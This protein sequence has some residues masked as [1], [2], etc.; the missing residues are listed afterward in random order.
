MA[1]EIRIPKLGLTMTDAVLSGWM[2]SAGEEVSADQ[3]VCALETDKVSFEV[4]APCTGWLHPVIAAGIRVEV[5]EVVGYVAADEAELDDLKTRFAVADTGAVEAGAAAASTEDDAD[6]AP[7]AA[8]ADSP[9]SPSP[10]AD[11]KPPPVVKKQTGDRIIASPAARKRCGQIGIKLDDIPGT[12]PG[13]RIVL[14]DVEKF[15][16]ADSVR[17]STARY[18]FESAVRESDLLTARETIPIRGIRKIIARNMKLSQTSQAQL[19]LQTEASA[20]DIRA[21]RKVFNARRADD[22]PRVSYNAIIIKAAAQALRL[23]PLINASVDGHKIKI[24]NQ[25]HIGVAM[26]FGQGLIVPKVRHADTLSI[27]A[28]SEALGDLAMRAGKKQLLPDELASG[29]FTITNLGA[30]DIDHFSPIVNFPE[31]AILGVG[32]MVE[33]PWIRD[34][35]VVADWRIS[36]SLT[37]D[38]RIIDGAL[39]A[40]FLKAIKDRIEETRLML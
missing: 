13:G 40:R 7:A 24:W 33:K 39:A 4:P 8:P 19:T 6:A 29:T 35:A 30:W 17:R 38:H 9:V 21:L 14:A 36:L 3:V 25:V 12:G 22:A 34:G 1:E 32:R 15:A 28:L 27:P 16:A 2:V 20:R 23:Y 11:V 18:E 26:D 37:F 10:A 31:S 5:G